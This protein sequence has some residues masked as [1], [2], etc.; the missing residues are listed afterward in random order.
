[1]FRRRFWV[2]LVLS[3]PVLLYSPMLQMWLGFTMPTFPGSMWLGPFFA[4][5]VFIYGG[6]PFLQM[7]WPEIQTRRPGMMT[8]ISLAITVAFVY[9]VAAFS[10]RWCC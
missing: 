9:S 1:M 2:S 8:L 4:L 10:G 3:I 6:V 7:A 5:I